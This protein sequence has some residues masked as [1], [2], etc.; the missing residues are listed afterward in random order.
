MKLRNQIRKQNNNQ[1]PNLYRYQ[2]IEAINKQGDLRYRALIAFLYLTG[3][4]V[5][6]VVKYKKNPQPKKKGMPPK[7]DSRI[8]GEPIRKKHVELR[9][10]HIIVLTVRTLKQRKLKQYRNIPIPKN[11]LENSFIKEFMAYYDSITDPET[12]LFN[13]TRVRAWQIL[14]KSNLFCHWLRHA[15]TTHLVQ[16]YDFSVPQLQQFFGWT[17]ADTPTH[18]VHLNVKNL[19][20]KMLNSD[21]A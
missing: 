6:E 18:Y 3:C 15:R 5:S 17:K 2:I 1:I 20:D 11:T 19:L 10:N 16:D 8:I 21:G 4:R 7:D 13:F 12:Y 14:Q 9:D